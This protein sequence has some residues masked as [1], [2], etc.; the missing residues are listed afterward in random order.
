MISET[1]A[2]IGVITAAMAEEA[3]AATETAADIGMTVTADISGRSVLKNLKQIALTLL[4][5]KY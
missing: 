2:D 4:R 3:M 1:V 5:N